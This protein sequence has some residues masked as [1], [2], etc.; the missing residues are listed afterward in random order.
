MTRLFAAYRARSGTVYYDDT[1]SGCLFQ[2][3]GREP[4]CAEFP[5]G[6]CDVGDLE[7]RMGFIEPSGDFLSR[8]ETQA[9]FGFDLA[10][11]QG[12]D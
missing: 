12:D 7:S 4:E 8:D 3:I 11:E 6:A 2:A 5:H 1:H 9:R 10:E